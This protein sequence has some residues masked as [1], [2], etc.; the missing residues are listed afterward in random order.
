MFTFL[1]ILLLLAGLHIH[2]EAQTKTVQTVY[3]GLGLGEARLGMKDKK[4][5]KLLSMKPVSSGRDTQYEGQTVYFHYFGE[6]DKNN[7]YSLEIYSD[8]RRR[9]F[10]FVINSREFLTPETIGVGSMEGQ[11]LKAYGKNLNKSK[12]GGIY[13][14][15]TI[16]GKKGTD[17]Y[18]KEGV[19]TQIVVRD[20]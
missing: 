3:P 11:L 5:I 1:K 10:M 16:G 13:A 6:K 19:V 15:Y 2:A 20:Y 4:V 18:V 8:V 7:N 14:K 17:F 12:K 9:V